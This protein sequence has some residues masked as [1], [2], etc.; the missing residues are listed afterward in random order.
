MAI[1]GLAVGDSHCR[2]SVALT[3]QCSVGL[4]PPAKRT[5]AGQRTYDDAT[6]R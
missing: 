2:T 6:V 5:E 1:F 3:W 4:L